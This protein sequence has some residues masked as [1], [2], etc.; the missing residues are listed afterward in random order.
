MFR[1]SELSEPIAREEAVCHLAVD[2]LKQ[3]CRVFE[4]RYRMSSR[5]FAE[6]F[7]KGRLGDDEAFFEWHALL[8]GIASWSRINRSLKKLRR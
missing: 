3:S 1:R 5:S 4:R 2:E 6:S 8:E 7:G